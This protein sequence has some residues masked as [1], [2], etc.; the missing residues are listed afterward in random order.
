[1][2]ELVVQIRRLL[3]RAEDD[4]RPRLCGNVFAA[5]GQLFAKMR[6]EGLIGA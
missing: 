3:P 4:S 1:M 2:S 5:T 6:D